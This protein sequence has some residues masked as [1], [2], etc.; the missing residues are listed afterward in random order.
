MKLLELFK[1]TGSISKVAKDHNFEIISLDIESCY[2][3]DINEDILKWDYKKYQK[4][5]N[6]IP[7]FIWASPPCNTFSI[8]NYPRHNRCPIT[9]YPF[10]DEAIKGTE[11]LY[12]TLDIID[13]FKSLNPKLLYVIENPIGMMRKDKKMKLLQRQSTYYCLYGDKKRKA[14]D[15]FNNFPNNLNLLKM[16]FHCKHKFKHINIQDMH[17]KKNINFRYSIPKKLVEHII[18]EFKKQYIL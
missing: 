1:G 10:S 3:P 17:G 2:E 11:I 12:K 4:E 14:T 7:D 5:N 8:L 15:F 18:N 9:A 16:P 13:Y 6:Y